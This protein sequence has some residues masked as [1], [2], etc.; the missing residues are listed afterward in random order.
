[1]R[2]LCEAFPAVGHLF[3]DFAQPPNGKS[4]LQ[5]IHL[6]S[7]AA[8][9]VLKLPNLDFVGIRNGEQACFW[10]VERASG[11]SPSFLNSAMTYEEGRNVL[12]DMGMVSEDSCAH[13]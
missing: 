13:A 5:S 4:S 3:L 9:I 10:E 8:S 6:E 1:M 12:E 11:S 7:L 2:G